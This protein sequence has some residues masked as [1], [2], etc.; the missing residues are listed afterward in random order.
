MEKLKKGYDRLT[1]FETSTKGYEWFGKSPGHEALSA[2]GIAQFNDM[3]KVTNFVSKADLNRN[4]DW[5]MDR[6]NPNNSGQWELNKKAIDTFG[7]A[8]QDITDAYLVWVMTQ[9][10][11]FTF[12][13]LKNEFTNLKKISEKN[14]DP[15]F[16]ALY[17][18]ALFN[19]GKKDEAKSISRKYVSKQNESTGAVEGAESSI[20]N[21]RGQSLLLETTSLALINWLNQDPSEFSAQIDLGVGYLLSSIKKGGRFGSTQSTVMT[22]KALV[23][24]TQIYAGIQ[25]KGK[26]VAYLNG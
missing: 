26:F 4:V 17:S 14:E 18:G 23:R 13:D 20:T 7:R 2:Y 24:Y 22:L 5:L 8:S 19:A 16:L 9:E 12:E 11:R 3:N 21:S 25:G 1:T 15:Y 6:R 10:G